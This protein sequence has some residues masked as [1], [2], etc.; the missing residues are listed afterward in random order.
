MKV[1]EY[2]KQIEKVREMVM[3]NRPLWY[4]MDREGIASYRYFVKLSKGDVAQPSVH[5]LVAIHDYLK[6]NGKRA[7]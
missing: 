2:E 1:A 5:K 3:N 6:A 7:A 4:R